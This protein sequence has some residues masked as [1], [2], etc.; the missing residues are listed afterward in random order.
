MKKM[1]LLMSVA[2]FV[3]ASLS[4]RAGGAC[5]AAAAGSKSAGGCGAKVEKAEAAAAPSAQPSPAVQPAGEVKAQTAC[6]VMGGAVNKSIYVDHN[7]K[8]VYLCC[9][10]CVST[11]KADPDKYV[12]QLTDAGVQ[13]EDAPAAQ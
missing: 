3:A 10:A 1:M 9:N 8:R 11:F 12:K 7:G 4:A 13:L 6:P 2:G 5:G